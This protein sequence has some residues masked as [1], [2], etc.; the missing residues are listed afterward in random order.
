MDRRS[1][2]RVCNLTAFSI[3]LPTTLV[4][5]QS[6]AQAIPA[7]GLVLRG[8]LGRLARAIGLRLLASPLAQYTSVLPSRTLGIVNTLNKKLTSGGFT[9][10][11]GNV[12]GT[13][14]QSFFYAAATNKGN[15]CAPFLVGDKLDAQKIPMIEGPGLIGLVA[16]A[17]I[18]S[19]K[20]GSKHAKNYLYPLEGITTAGGNFEVGYKNPARFRSRMGETTIGYEVT[21]KKSGSTFGKI[22]VKAA[23]HDGRLLIDNEFDIEVQDTLT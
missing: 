2:I 20:H 18:E 1:F 16:A 19:Q 7:A 11:S 23:R 22:L 4:V 17:E 8:L 6:E 12:Y 3:V 9:D 21:K 13:G 14:P 5:A 10:F 15:L